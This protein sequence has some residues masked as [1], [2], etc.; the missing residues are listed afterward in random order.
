MGRK[1]D[2]EILFAK[3]EEINQEYLRACDS[4]D[5]CSDRLILIMQDALSMIAET[6]SLINSIKHTPFR[7]KIEIKELSRERKKIIDRIAIE[8]KQ[9]DEDRCAGMAAAMAIGAGGV[10]ALSFKDF[11]RKKIN[12]SDNNVL[13]YVLIGIFIIFVLAAYGIWLLI[14]RCNTAKR[15]TSA[16]LMKQQEIEEKK[17]QI[18]KVEQK[19]AELTSINAIINMSLYQLS[20]YRNCNYKT[21]PDNDQKE[22]FALKN[23]AQSLAALLKQ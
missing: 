20:K 5:E 18:E 4:A 6:E 17:I 15:T 22:L 13:L 3:L 9:R 23:N 16:I 12:P 10:G 7:F 11:I 14:N 8:K 19:I 1:K 2:K 21:I